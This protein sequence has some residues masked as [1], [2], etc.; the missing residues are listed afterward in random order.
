MAVSLGG[1]SAEGDQSR[2]AGA[3]LGFYGERVLYF[4][5][6]IPKEDLPPVLVTGEAVPLSRPKARCEFSGK[7]VGYL[8]TCAFLGGIS[9]QNKT[10]GKF[11]AVFHWIPILSASRFAQQTP[12][13]FGS[14]LSPLLQNPQSFGFHNRCNPTQASEFP[15]RKSLLRIGHCRTATSRL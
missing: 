12:Y 1:T 15:V 3:S 5:R 6:A 8:Y 14:F 10:A 11:P 13:V 4:K 2:L 7:R 9:N